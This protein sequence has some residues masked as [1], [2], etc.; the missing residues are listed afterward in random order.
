MMMKQSEPYRR[1]VKRKKASCERKKEGCEFYEAQETKCF[2]D[3]QQLE[4]TLTIPFAYVCH[5]SANLEH[6]S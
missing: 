1:N 3:V 4:S 6:A 5:T 2:Y